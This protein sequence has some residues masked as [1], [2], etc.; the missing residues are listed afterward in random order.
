MIRFRDLS[1]RTLLAVGGLALLS[2]NAAAVT[3][4][5][6]ER[7]YKPQVGQQGKDVVWVPTPYEIVQGMLGLA[8]VTPTDLLYDLG[9]GDGIIAISAGKLGATAVG[10][11]YDPAMAR[12]AKCLVEAEGMTAKVNII[13]GDIF[14]ED[15]S[16]A[17]VVTMY[18]LPELNRCIRHR[19]LA[20][21]PGTRVVSHDFRMGEWDPDDT[22]EHS[23]RMA[24]LW[25][26]PARVEGTWVV[27]DEVGTNVTVRLTQSFQKVGGEIVA[28]APRQSLVGAT[29]KANEISFAFNDDKGAA[30]TFT[31]TV[32]GN[33]MTGL[34]RNGSARVDATAAVQGALR[35]GPWS[36]M[37]QGCQRF[38]GG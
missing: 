4:A 9:A 37:A 35:P 18:L 8:K 15:F 3:R 27:K 14:R 23:F 5:D 11:E 28:G 17:T 25:V 6:C 10:I 19:L 29:L 36:E 7:D 33:E 24:H 32:R 1:L 31:G 21:R 26:V 34:L 12:F 22:F 38:Y 16:K 2:A 13:Q 30:R 20:M